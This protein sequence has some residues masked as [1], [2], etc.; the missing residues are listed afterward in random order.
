MSSGTNGKHGRTSHCPDIFRASSC[1]TTA[2][3]FPRIWWELLLAQVQTA[4]PGRFG[5]PYE[6]LSA[7]LILNSLYV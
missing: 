5:R 2:K 3:K 7:W 4:A 6:S 1:P